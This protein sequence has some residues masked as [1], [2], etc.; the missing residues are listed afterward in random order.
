MSKHWEVSYKRAIAEVRTPTALDEKVLERIRGVKALRP[1]RP[2]QKHSGLLSKAASSFSA[3]AIVVVLLHPA[4]YI[5]AAPGQIVPESAQTGSRGL[6]RY[7]AKPGTIVDTKSDRWHALRTEVDAGS[8]TQLCA[9][10]RREQR[11][12]TS[13]SLPADLASKA[14]QHCRILP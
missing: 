9:Q 14:R 8:Y 13:D 2:P 11:S 6:E 3:L 4:Q 10:W 1:I 5:G 12:N 7:R